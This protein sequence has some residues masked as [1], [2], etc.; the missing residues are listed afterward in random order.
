MQGTIHR[1]IRGKGFG[2]IQTEERQYFFHHSEVKSIEFRQLSV[3]D[4]VEFQPVEEEAGKNPRAVEVLVLVKAVAPP[5]RPVPEAAA[6]APQPA[7]RPERRPPRAPAPPG[8]GRAGQGRAGPGPQ[9]SGNGRRARPVRPQ[10]PRA[11]SSDNFASGIFAEDNFG[12]SAPSAERHDGDLEFSEELPYSGSGS[13]EGAAPAGFDGPTNQSR[14]TGTRPQGDG[15]SAAG[16][17]P[18]RPTGGGNRFRRPAGRPDRPQGRPRSRGDD[19]SQRP[20]ASGAPGERAEGIIRSINL[21]RGFGFIET[22]TGDIFFH[23]SGVKAG[24]EAL[25]IGSRVAF[26]FGEGDRGAKAE[27]ISAV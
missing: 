22:S 5:P 13:S 3:G 15:F 7:P 14:G 8:D 1:L 2:F 6:E 4:I 23:R 10:G 11:P 9:A 18:R 17:R 24:F 26:V 12:D 20:K 19:K 16:D 27:D 25:D 21:E